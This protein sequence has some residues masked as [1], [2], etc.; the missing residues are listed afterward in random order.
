MKNE[1]RTPKE[2]E[3]LKVKE[4]I[5]ALPTMSDEELKAADRVATRLKKVITDEKRRRKGRGKRGGRRGGRERPNAPVLRKAVW[6]SMLDG[7]RRP[8]W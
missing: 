2:I 8:A 7:Q 4:I 6:L 1:K 3:N 5:E